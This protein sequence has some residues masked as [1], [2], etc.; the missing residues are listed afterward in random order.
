MP[1]LVPSP[2]PLLPQPRS[3][4]PACPDRESSETTPGVRNLRLLAVQPAE[5]GKRLDH[6]LQA[7]GIFPSRHQIQQLISTGFVQVNRS[8]VKPSHRLKALDEILVELPAPSPSSCQA[9][10]IPLT[11]VHQDNDLLVVNK[12]AGMV[13]HPAAGHSG[14][15]LVNALL[16]HCTDL[17]GIGGVLRPGIVH[18]LDKDTS[19]LLVV[20]KRDEIHLQLSRQFQ[21]H[22]IIR[23]YL[24]LV[25]GSLEEERGSIHA[26][27]GRHPRDRKKMSTQSPR[28][29]NAITHWQV[30]DRFSCVTFVRFRLHTGRTHQIRVHMADRG[31]PIVGDR[32]YGGRISRQ[33]SGVCPEEQ[34][35]RIESLDRLFLHAERL[36]FH[37]PT[38]G[39]LCLFTCPLPPDLAEILHLLRNGEE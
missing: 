23:E 15:T 28:G 14:R 32:V 1:I 37:H 31:T 5:A 17:S 4:M 24:G 9:E 7:T 29:R 2:T 8:R 22:S 38:T 20:A 36:G 19:G 33:V 3:D 35:K 6:F 26:A 39:Q 18:R 13:V 16:H 25:H 12:P 34:R 10:P 30:L 21:C 11:I 27:I